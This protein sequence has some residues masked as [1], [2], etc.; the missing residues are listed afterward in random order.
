MIIREIIFRSKPL[1]SLLKKPLVFSLFLFIGFYC[2]YSVISEVRISDL[3]KAADGKAA[4]LRAVTE[5]KFPVSSDQKC[6]EDKESLKAFLSEFFRNMRDL[7]CRTID[8]ES[9]LFST[10][11][12]PIVYY[13]EKDFVPESGLLN[14]LIRKNRSVQAGIFLNQESFQSLKNQV[15][16]KYF[17]TVMMNDFA[18]KLNISNDLKKN[19]RLEVSSAFAEGEAVP[20][21]KSFTVEN[22]STIAIELSNVLKEY[23]RENGTGF[24]LNLD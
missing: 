1:P 19:V 9:Y 13:K 17:M 24:F 3:L 20:F 6:E 4:G 18:M 12:I 15:N 11:D 21:S 16:E 10:V 5:L 7:N 23:I 8:M 14:I 22:G 2:K